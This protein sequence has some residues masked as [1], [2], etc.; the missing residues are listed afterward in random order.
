MTSQPS[1]TYNF[2]GISYNPSYFKTSSSGLTTGAANALYLR[3]TYADTA[4]SLETFSAGINTTTLSAS[5]LVEA[6]AGITVI[7]TSTLSSLKVTTNK[8]NN[9]I[10]I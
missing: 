1:P 2:P 5:G 4:T 8:I 10:S 9:C 7:G 6:N 3:K